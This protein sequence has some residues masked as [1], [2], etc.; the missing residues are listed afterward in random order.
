MGT[1]DIRGSDADKRT[2]G[3][4]F[5][6]DP[7]IVT[8]SGYFTHRTT[9]YGAIGGGTDGLEGQLDWGSRLGVRGYFGDVHG[10]FARAGMGLQLLGNNKIYRSHFELPMVEAGY[11]V[12]SDALLFELAATGGLIL[13]GRYF[14]GD[15]A[16]R[17]I[18]SEFEWGGQVTLQAD[19]FRLAGRFMRIQAGQT[20]PGTPI[21]ELT[22]QLCLNP[23]GVLLLCAD[24]AWHRGDV[25]L[26]G[27]GFSESTALYLG[28]TI[29]LGVVRTGARGG[30]MD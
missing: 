2:W 10:P 26:P 18:D 9:F 8:T 29:G 17:R 1:Y 3:F 11:Q 7:D 14:T 4:L 12:H 5:S 16:E 28:G 13:G 21:D 19:H 15:D 23:I 30:L 24:G 6:L 27:G 20:E 22:G 25:A